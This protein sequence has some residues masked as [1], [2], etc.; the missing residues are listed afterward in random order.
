M[1]RPLAVV[2][3][4]VLVLVAAP[5]AARAASSDLTIDD[6][7]LGHAGTWAKVASAKAKGRTLLKATR[8]GATLTAK[9]KAKAGGAV[10][11][12]VGQ[13]RGTVAIAVNGRRART[14]ATA[15]RR[16][17]FKTYAFSGKGT[18]KLTVTKA[19]KGVYV[20]AVVLK[21]LGR[22]TGT[23][24]SPAGSGGAG[25]G[26]AAS[27]SGPGGIGSGGGA[28][29]LPPLAGG[30][31]AQVDTDAAGNGGNGGDVTTVAVSPD[32]RHV[33]FWSPATNLVPGVAN[34]VQHLYLKT[35]ATGAI[36]VL[37][38]AQDGTL[39][40]DVSSDSGAH[41]LAWK[42]DSN[43]VLFTSGATNL[44]PDVSGL[45]APYLYAKEIDDNSVGLLAEK[46]TSNA[47]WSPDGKKIAYGSSGDYC[48][49][50]QSPCTSTSVS[51]SKLY[52]LDLTTFKHIP[53]S[54]TQSGVQPVVNGGPNGSYH[55]VWSPDSTRVAFESDSPQ[56]V[57]N[58]TNTATDVFVKD[59]TSLA[60]A[61]VSVTAAGS[62]ANAS[63]EWPAWS[64]DGTRIAFD[65][66]A[67]NFVAGDNNSGED[68]FVKEL[69]TGAVS[70]ISAEP[71]GEFK[72]FSH[73]IPKWSPDGTR[74]AFNSKSVDLIP[75]YVDSNQREDVY[76]R[77]LRTGTFQVVSARADG[78]IG[79]GDSTQWS[80]LGST[81]GWLPDG[82]GLVFLSRSTNFSADG[83]AFNESVFVKSGL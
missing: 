78:V 76:V 54:A 13:G 73:R 46:A 75:G 25:A 32:G 41:A 2:L 14:V 7:A 55:P 68:V 38:A 23:G 69:G 33:A 59:I 3:P 6:R 21:G 43:E 58:D 63:S 45:S 44:G 79:N 30:P 77:D 34:G 64:P 65:S 37:D 48:F 5:P 49:P 70:A 18:V 29:A 52:V 1:R 62:Q 39:S 51:D 72:L 35:L 9:T 82:H 40:N 47:A 31:L 57:P 16:T 80:V 67:D 19:G 27:P 36:R 17:A 15:A 20:D 60:I 66:K 83:N 81:G 26:G 8:K 53:V 24:S 61:R 12:Q 50:A 11:V 74:I 56:L 22:A 28:A 42:P 10:V 4:A 71:S